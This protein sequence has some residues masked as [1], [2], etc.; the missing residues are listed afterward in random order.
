MRLI[1]AI[2]LALAL[3]NHNLWIADGLG[4]AP[5]PTLQPSLA[6]A[7]YILALISIFAFVIRRQFFPAWVWQVGFVTYVSLRFYELLARGLAL[8]GEDLV[9]N[10][11]VVVAY[12]FLVLPAGL[13]MFYLGHI[14]PLR[15]RKAGMS[16]EARTSFAMQ[17]KSTP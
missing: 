17:N 8:S 2:Y 10:V 13:V 9:T 7:L 12:L 11:D 1:A 14:V 15:E 16:R 6:W 5:L 3:S 4:T